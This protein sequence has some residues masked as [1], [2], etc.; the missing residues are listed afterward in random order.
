MPSAE[1]LIPQQAKAYIGER[2][3]QVRLAQI[4]L[5]NDRPPWLLGKSQPDI[6]FTTVD[7][8]HNIFVLKND[9]SE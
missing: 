7:G 5:H 9:D 2:A 1:P 3:S 6:N 4:P 8:L